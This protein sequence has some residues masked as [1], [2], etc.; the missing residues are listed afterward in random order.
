MTSAQRVAKWKWA[1]NSL[2]AKKVRGIGRKYFE[3]VKATKAVSLVEKERKK[4]GKMTKALKLL[5]AC[6]KQ[7]G[8]V[9]QNSDNSLEDLDIEQLLTEVKYMRLTI[10]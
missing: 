8:P 7:G 5:E 10:A 1:K 6:K 3:A 4:K 9:T 2:Q